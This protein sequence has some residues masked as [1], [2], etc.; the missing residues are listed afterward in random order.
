MFKG[1]GRRVLQQIGWPDE[2]IN[3][4]CLV[5]VDFQINNEYFLIYVPCSICCLSE[6]TIYPEFCI[7]SPNPRWGSQAWWVAMAART[8]EQKGRG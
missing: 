6:I 7:L 2:Q 8:L 5:K 1:F 3:I 4:G